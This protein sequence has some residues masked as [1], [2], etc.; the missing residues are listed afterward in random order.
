MISKAP[1]AE[2]FV[3]RNLFVPERGYHYRGAFVEHVQL[4]S[5]A[6]GYQILSL[7]CGKVAVYLN[8]AG[9]KLRL[10]LAQ[11]SRYTDGP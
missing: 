1:Q 10:S 6:S 5:R 8:P 7:R 3:E 9:R 4:F 11:V 2:L